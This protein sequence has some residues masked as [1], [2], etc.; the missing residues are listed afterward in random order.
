MLELLCNEGCE[1]PRAAWW[2]QVQREQPR[3]ALV[4]TQARLHVE[5]FCFVFFFN[6]KKQK[7]TVTS[8][9]PTGGVNLSLCEQGQLPHS[10]T[11]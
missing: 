11:Q 8:A 4:L 6:K 5:V 10:D 9:C 2:A 1:L 3:L 7:S